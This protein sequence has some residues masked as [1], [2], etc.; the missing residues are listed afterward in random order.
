MQVRV[1]CSVG[2]PYHCLSPSVCLLI[3]HT[4]WGCLVPDSG[5]DRQGENDS[6]QDTVPV[7]TGITALG[8]LIREL[9]LGSPALVW[10]HS[11]Y[12]V[13]Q[14][15]ASV[16][17]NAPSSTSLRFRESLPAPRCQNPGDS[18]REACSQEA[19]RRTTNPEPKFV[20]KIQ[21]RPIQFLMRE[22]DI[23]PGIN[24]YV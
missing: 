24:I 18:L 19:N 8:L 6:I 13:P 4:L 9:L 2:S 10:W 7:F 15:P 21:L 3:S 12:R 5:A 17:P 23:Y 16:L 11:L 20:P 1:S 22:S 14:N